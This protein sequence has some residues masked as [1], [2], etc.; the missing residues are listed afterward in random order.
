[1]TNPINEMMDTSMEKLRQMVD[2]NTVL[3]QPITTADGTTV[4]PITK[5]KYSFAGGGSEFTTK[6]SGESK[7]YGGGTG[8]VVSVTPVAFLISKDASCRILPI[9]EPAST[10]VDRMIELIPDFADKVWQY[11]QEKKAEKAEQV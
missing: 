9:P 1:M 11:I 3:G 5:V 10:S 4:I 8:G 6:H 7:P 2:A